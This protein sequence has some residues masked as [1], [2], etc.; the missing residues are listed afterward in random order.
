MAHPGELALGVAPGVILSALR[1]FFPR[2]LAVEMPDE[3]RHAVRLHGREDRI[4]LP[5][6]QRAHLIDCPGRE[7]RIEA[8]IDAAAQLRA[9]RREKH[10]HGA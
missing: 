10:L 4:E 6:S 1:R 5:R 7:H 3:P 8:R 9:I 2:N